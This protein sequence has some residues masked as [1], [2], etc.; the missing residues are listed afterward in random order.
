MTTRITNEQ[1]ER[2]FRLSDQHQ[3]T[4]F[5]CMHDMSIKLEKIKD[6]QDITVLMWLQ[7]SAITYKAHRTTTILK[8]GTVPVRFL[9]E[10]SDLLLIL[11]KALSSAFHFWAFVK[12]NFYD[13]DSVYINVSVKPRILANPGIFARVV[14]N[15][16]KADKQKHAHRVA[17]PA[18]APAPSLAPA[19]ALVTTATVTTNGITYRIEDLDVPLSR[20]ERQTHRVKYLA[21]QGNMKTKLGPDRTKLDWYVNDHLLTLYRFRL[22]TEC[23]DNISNEE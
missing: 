11:A 9:T 2:I 4:F 6:Q 20:N 22:Q 16:N 5:K 13:E 23:F 18:L 10:H 3:M 8:I 12:I 17:I 14:K 1:W 21:R 7:K 15:F 19:P